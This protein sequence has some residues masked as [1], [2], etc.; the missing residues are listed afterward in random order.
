MSAGH[1]RYRRHPT[2][3]RPAD[4]FAGPGISAPRKADA[5]RAIQSGGWGYRCT[6]RQ[7]ILT[8]S[9]RPLGNH[10]PI[11]PRNE[12]EEQATLKA[13]HGSAGE[14]EQKTGLLTQT[15]YSLK[16]RQGII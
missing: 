10:L 14:F 5:W 9:E 1:A 12:T 8:G 7:S 3:T 4:S 2:E 11:V 16:G 15:K 13:H 6:F